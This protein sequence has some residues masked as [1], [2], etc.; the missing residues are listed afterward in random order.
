MLNY[1]VHRHHHLLSSA[2]SAVVS[3]VRQTIV[4]V[5]EEVIIA[6][7]IAITIKSAE[8]LKAIVLKEVTVVAVVDAVA[9]VAEE[10]AA[11]FVV[12]VKVHHAKRKRIANGCY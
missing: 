8:I 5:T 4:A 7:A 10:V 9:D 6:E 12:R 2:R 1:L 11:E 3:V